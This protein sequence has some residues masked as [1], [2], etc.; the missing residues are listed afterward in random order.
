MRK[1]TDCQTQRD[2]ELHTLDHRKMNIMSPCFSLQHGAMSYMIICVDSDSKHIL[3]QQ[4]Y[5]CAPLV[6][7]V[8]GLCSSVF[9]EQIKKGMH[10]ESDFCAY[11]LQAHI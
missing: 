10:K 4:V 6:F 1:G 5:V 2:I 9:Q 3:V 7:K 11:I 8:S